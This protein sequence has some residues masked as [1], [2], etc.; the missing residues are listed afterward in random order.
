MGIGM[1][2]DCDLLLREVARDE[3]LTRGLDDVEAR[4]LVEWVIDWAQLFAD[5]S[6]DT[7]EAQKLVGRVFRRG[8]AIGRF[9]KLWCEPN[10][11]PAAAQLFASQRFAWP[12][13][14]HRVTAPDLM[15]SILSWEN[16]HPRD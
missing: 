9:V 2:V 4:M 15:H 10:G 8:Q 3:S 11:Q 16:Q 1:G 5:A 7:A 6:K 13:P 12:L 14:T